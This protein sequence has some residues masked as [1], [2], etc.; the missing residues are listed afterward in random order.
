MH[1]AVVSLEQIGLGA[2]IDII[3]PVFLFAEYC[4]K[5]VDEFN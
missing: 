3:V 4:I 1:S 2:K 5:P